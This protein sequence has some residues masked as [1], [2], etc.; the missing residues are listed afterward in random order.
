MIALS[1]LS[2]NVH[3][4]RRSKK[5]IP[6]LTRQTDA[7]VMCLQEF[8]EKKIEEFLAL[9][10]K[11]KYA[12]AYAPS[13]SI[14]KK[15]YG[16]LTLLRKHILSIQTTKIIPLG[17]N[18]M[19]KAVLRT[20]LQ[21]TALLTEMNYKGKRFVLV[22][23]QLVSLASNH[24]RYGQVKIILKALQTYR[25]PTFI[26]GDFNIPSLKVNKKLFG[27]M[28]LHEYNSHETYKPTCRFGPLWYQVDY[29]FARRGLVKN[30]NIERVNFSD[31]HPIT[32]DI[33]F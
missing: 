7:D 14:F 10:P 33:H 16:E 6:W 8:P 20:Q 1:V 11:N 23:P 2:Y 32:V 9:L 31:H 28:K 24:V 3:F 4:G 27:F 15:V 12:F 19:E 21:R 29:A 30:F 26:I 25:I 18:R 5:F 13:M 22:N 17:T